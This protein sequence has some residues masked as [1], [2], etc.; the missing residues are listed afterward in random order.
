MVQVDVV[1][2]GDDGTEFLVDIRDFLSITDNVGEKGLGS[3]WPAEKYFEISSIFFFRGWLA[4]GSESSV[5]LFLPGVLVEIVV[6]FVIFGAF[7]AK[8]VGCQI[9][10]FRGFSILILRVGS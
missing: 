9:F 5:F 10:F 1:D 7:F 8:G 4:A 3:C 2:I 6:H